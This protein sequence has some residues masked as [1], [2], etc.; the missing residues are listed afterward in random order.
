MSINS[1]FWI[2]LKTDAQAEIIMSY[3]ASVFDTFQVVLTS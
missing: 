3:F 2:H 1:D